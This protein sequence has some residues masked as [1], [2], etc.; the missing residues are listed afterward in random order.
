ML[1]GSS[2]DQ[3][4]E[5]WES[6]RKI[7]ALRFRA[8]REILRERR[9][10]RR[11]RRRSYISRWNTPLRS[12]TASHWRT[13]V[14]PPTAICGIVIRKAIV[15]DET[16][17]AIRRLRSRWRPIVAAEIR[18][19]KSGRRDS[20]WKYVGIADIRA[21][22]RQPPRICLRDECWT[23]ASTSPR[24][25]SMRPDNISRNF[26]RTREAVVGR[27]LSGGAPRSASRR[28][29]SRSPPRRSARRG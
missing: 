19:R 28:T 29:P 25:P 12:G 24:T 8:L 26:L 2:F 23:F 22:A 20:R 4:S 14:R 10:H 27:S 5:A 6:D 7:S 1:A 13:I 16:A 21:F 18:C 3:K 9:P 11:G 17:R 15:L